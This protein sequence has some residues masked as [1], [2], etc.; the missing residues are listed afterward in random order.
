MKMFM[1]IY[2]NLKNNIRIEI[3]IL[4]YIII[5]ILFQLILNL[6]HAR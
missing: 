5:I 2:F 1:L 6:N 4:K 3:D